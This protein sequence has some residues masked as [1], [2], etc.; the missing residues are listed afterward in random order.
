MRKW[1]LGFLLCSAAFLGPAITSASAC[2]MCAEANKV[3]KNRPKAYMYSI[4]FM[5]SM[6]A[7]ICTGFGIGFY[8]LHLKAQNEEATE[9][10]EP[11]E[12]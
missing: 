4:I 3:D 7:I 11:F 1:L 8:R 6:P 5:I 2:P 9:T 10:N 12:N